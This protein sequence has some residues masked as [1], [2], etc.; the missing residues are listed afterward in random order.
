MPPSRT[1][2]SPSR[3]FSGPLGGESEGDGPKLSTANLSQLTR[4]IP[5]HPTVWFCISQFLACRLSQFDEPLEGGG[6]LE[7]RDR[8]EPAEALGLEP[9]LHVGFP[10]ASP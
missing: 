10:P 9:S 4:P 5:L 3:S 1:L 6:D 2:S 7:G 8:L